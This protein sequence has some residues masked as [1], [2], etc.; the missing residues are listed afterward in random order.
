M[1][2]SKSRSEASTMFERSISL[3]VNFR[4]KNVATAWWSSLL[5]MST[6]LASKRSEP[7]T[8][9]VH[10]ARFEPELGPVA[11]RADSHREHRESITEC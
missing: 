10:F 11:D 5:F 3:T 7:I 6:C 1:A 9:F 2:K 4:K 8:W